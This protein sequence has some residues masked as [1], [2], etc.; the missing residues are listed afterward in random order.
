[1]VNDRLVMVHDVCEP[2]PL[3]QRWGGS[4]CLMMEPSVRIYDGSLR[5]AAATI[6]CSCDSYELSKEGYAIVIHQGQK[7]TQHNREFDFYS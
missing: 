7:N 4:R 3:E 1:M 2:Y 6:M 5:S